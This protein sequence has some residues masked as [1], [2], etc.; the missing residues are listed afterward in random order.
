MAKPKQTLTD[1][2][3]LSGYKDIFKSTVERTDF[4]KDDVNGETIVEIP[5][6]ELHPPEFHPFQVNHDSA[7][8]RLVASIK[9]YGVREPG[10]VRPRLNGGY[11]LISGNRRKLACELAEIPTLPVIIRE[12]DDDS[13][14]IAMVDSNLEQRDTI[15]PSEMA[16]AYHVKMEALNH[17]GKKGDKHSHEILME[18][19]GK[20]KNTIFRLIRLTEL[21]IALL[22][23][24]DTK[25]L[26]LT[27]AAEL[28]YLTKTE[29]TAVADAMDKY[30][31][32][33]S[34]SQSQRLKKLSLAGELTLETMDEILSEE[35]K[36]PW[37]PKNGD[38]DI[39]TD[40]DKCKNENAALGQ[41]VQVAQTQDHQDTGIIQFR[42]YFPAEYSVQQMRD[43][44]VGLLKKWQ[45]K[46]ISA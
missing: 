38:E 23:K 29:Q 40:T 15:L 44:I 30:D 3:L 16:W 42:D 12:L 36:L 18:Q 21:V 6:A 45:P 33:P 31:V 46:G 10:L 24:V 20:S 7:M 9:E 34:L 14:A 13:A 25:K 2:T 26:A 43:V 5:L 4:K 41:T 28:S 1:T 19:T 17:S 8:D 37:E 39:Y 32:K 22:D 11:E 35:K 27:P